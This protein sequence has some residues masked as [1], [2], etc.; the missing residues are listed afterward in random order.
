MMKK[1]FLRYIKILSLILLLGVSYTPVY[2]GNVSDHLETLLK[3]KGL[4]PDSFSI[5]IWDL[6]EDMPVVTYRAKQPLIPASIMKSVTTATLRTAMPYNATI[7]TNIYYEGEIGDTV[8]NGNIIVEGGGDPSL[9]DGRHK[10]QTDIVEEI[11]GMLAEFNI[12]RFCGAIKVDT[13]YFAGPSTPPSWM[14]GDLSHS[15][16]TGSHA[17][18]YQGNAS[19]KTAV[20]DPA[21]VFRSKLTE[22]LKARGIEVEEKRLDFKTGGKRLLFSHRSPALR[23]LMSSCMFRSD[24]L[25]AESFLRLYGALKGTDGSTAQGAKMMTRHWDMKN[26]PLEGV[27]IVDGSG[28]SRSNRLTAEFLGRMLIELKS[29]PVYVSFFPLVGEEGTV[30]NFLKSTRL[31]EYLCL[32]T[33]SMS[34]IQSY[35]GYLLDED[36]IPSHVVVII[37]NNLKDR[38]I[39]REDLGTFLLEVFRPE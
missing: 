1:I 28:L 16:G 10:G 37:A 9:G 21:R 39:F 5:F 24:N 29:D 35:A 3:S 25:Y 7:P 18:N 12:R 33:G 11:A 34:G 6:D 17:F 36:Y 32:K 38:K 23:D 15:Y 14:K 4:D 13:A 20:T 22:A 27:E 2:A 30:K 19:G 8:F 31:Q 26:L